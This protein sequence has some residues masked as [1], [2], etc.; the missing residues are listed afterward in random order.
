MA[1]GSGFFREL[2]RRHVWRVAAAYLVVGWLLIQVATQIFPVFYV[3]DWGARL[4]V[5][6][7]AI[8]FPVAVICAWIYEV[9]PAGIRRTEPAGSPD[10]RAERDARL[11]GRKLDVL[12]IA[13]LALAVALL[14][15]RVLVLQRASAP[16]TSAMRSPD[17]PTGAAASGLHPPSTI[18]PP[19]ASSVAIPEKSVAVLPFANESG[20]QD[21]QYFSDGLSEDLIDALSQLDGLKVISRNSAFQFRDSKDSSKAIGAKLGVAHLLEGTVRH[22]EGTV[23]I[24]AT[25]VNAA[26]GSALWSHQ[27]DRP[28]KD[29]FALQD[30]ITQAVAG[31]L[32]AKLL[33]APGVVAQ[34]DRPPGGSLAAYAAYQRG[35]AYAALTTDAGTRHAI[36]AFG[37]AIRID[38]R[39]V[40]A[41][42]QLSR[43]WTHLGASGV[44]TVHARSAASTA[45][46]TALQLDPD[47]SLAHQA[48]AYWFAL[49]VMDWTSAQAE[50]QRALQLS[51]NDAEA[52]FGYGRVLAS[53]G[54][55]AHALQLTRRALVSDPRRA[56]YYFLLS[57]GLA[58]RGELDEARQAINTAIAMQ[59]GAAGASFQLALID[60]LRG[61]AKAALSAAQ[62]EPPGVW[63]D[64]GL[65]LAA[66]LGADR[67]AADR[68]LAALIRNHADVSPY[69]IAETY[70]LRRD[71]DNVFRWLERAW[72]SRD[73]G[74]GLMLSDPIILRYKDDPRFAAFCRKVGLPTT[75]DAVAMK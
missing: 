59:P 42:A 34:S 16:A 61:D 4:V 39:Y 28:Y 37:E 43:A 15:W 62:Q 67:L 46:A 8:G 9:T 52:Q 32:K 53:L 10:A 51:P 1:D 73:A 66:Q 23:R 20:E 55:N 25:L 31:A 63:H 29:L 18:S 54:Q 69:Q 13:V 5:I 7:I 17:S 49:A 68:A 71:P 65:A 41:Y 60:I 30:A 12:I 6:L 56:S 22:A 40:S 47:S 48:R 58:A 11:V 75:T 44:D 24:T 21:Q 3:P 74:L 45:M 36:D 33:V 35:I 19:S 70:A 57:S 26:D 27:Y 2:K 38:P 14:A 64:I 72:T 50:Y